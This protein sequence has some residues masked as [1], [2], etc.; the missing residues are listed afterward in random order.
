MLDEQSLNAPSSAQHSLADYALVRQREA[1]FSNG[2]AT[3]K[4]I[5]AQLN[6]GTSGFAAGDFGQQIGAAYGRGAGVI[7][8]ADLHQMV[9]DQA[10]RAGGKGTEAIEKSGMDERRVSDCRASRDEWTAR[11]SS[12]FAVLRNQ[13]TAASWLAAPAPI[14][15]L[16][17]VTPMRRLQ[18]R[19]FPKTQRRSPMTS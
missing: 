11:Q 4:Q 12:E 5:N 13:A 15:S 6:S 7:L 2:V 18:W 1:V 16:D 17:F 14:G 9:A 3:L 19:S 8:A 10:I